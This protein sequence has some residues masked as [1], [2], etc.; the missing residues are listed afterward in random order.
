MKRPT[1]ILLASMA[2]ASFLV[3]GPGTALADHQPCAGHYSGS[4]MHTEAFG[5]GQVS[6]GTYTESRDA[7]HVDANPEDGNPCHP[8]SCEVLFDG[9]FVPSISSPPVNSPEV[10]A[11]GQTIVPSQPVIAG[12]PL[13]TGFVVPV[14]VPT[15]TPWCAAGN[16]GVYAGAQGIMTVRVGT[17]RA[18]VIAW[19]VLS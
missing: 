17:E 7:W 18:P 19:G 1:T 14:V 12:Q 10:R 13:V 6:V 2:L 4:K 15:P 16:I 11:L 9:F 8:P 3:L 5:I